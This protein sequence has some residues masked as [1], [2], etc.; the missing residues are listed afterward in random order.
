MIKIL[1]FRRTN[2]HFFRKNP[3]E[4]VLE[5]RGSQE[6]SCLFASITSFK[7][8]SSPTCRNSSKGVQRL[9]WMNKGLLTKLIY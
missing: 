8:K 6:G 2:F 5:G 1:N 4:M 9:A 3:E 7:F